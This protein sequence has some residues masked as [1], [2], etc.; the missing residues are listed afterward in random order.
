M[1][2]LYPTQKIGVLMGTRNN[3]W[4]GFLLLA[5]PALANDPHFDSGEFNVSCKG[6]VRESTVTAI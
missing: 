4:D 6:A 1:C 3:P 2:G 5:F